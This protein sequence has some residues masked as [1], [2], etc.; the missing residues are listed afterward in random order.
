[1]HATEIREVKREWN[2][3][4]EKIKAENFPKLIKDAI[5]NHRYKLFRECRT[6]TLLTPPN[7]LDKSYLNYSKQKV[8]RKT[9]KAAR[10]KTMHYIE[11]IHT[12]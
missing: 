11:N 8:K 12:E 10:G 6:I 4:A 9:F 3:I 7:Q 1:M 5:K 2:R